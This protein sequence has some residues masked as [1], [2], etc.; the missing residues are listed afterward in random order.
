SMQRHSSQLE[1]AN[2]LKS[3]YLA[4]MS[5]ELRTPI[6]T[7]IGYASLMLDRIYG[8]LTARQDEGLKR[9][10]GAAQHLIALINDILHLA[11][12]EAGRMPLHLDDVSLGDIMTEISQ[13]IEPD[14]N[15][16][17]LT[18]NVEF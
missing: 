3:E 16:K 14:V 17:Q 10:Q 12:I 13:Q 8:D 11:K 4:S 9:I 1:K 15:K 6:D 5:N 7:L 2:R 18:F